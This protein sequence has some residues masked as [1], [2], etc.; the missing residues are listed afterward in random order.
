MQQQQELDESVHPETTDRE[1]VVDSTTLQRR[2]NDR[3]HVRTTIVYTL[4]SYY[5]ILINSLCCIQY[6]A[7]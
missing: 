5:L 2:E 7:G 6:L 4:C 1:D 3:N